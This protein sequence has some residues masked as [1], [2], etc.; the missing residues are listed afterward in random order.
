MPFL[1]DAQKRWKEGK[2][3][4]TGGKSLPWAL[5]VFT[6]LIPSL[7][8]SVPSPF[9]L[10]ELGERPMERLSRA[11]LI[12]SY[13]QLNCCPDSASQLTAAL[14]YLEPDLLSFIMRL[15][16]AAQTAGW[17]FYSTCHLYNHEDVKRTLQHIIYSV[18]WQERNSGPGCIACWLDFE[19]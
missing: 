4:V 16:L 7:I 13:Y 8:L 3:N 9:P 17:F 1:Y 15:R 12:T 2:Q 10:L 19:M 18:L 6:S 5:S 11:C 14:L